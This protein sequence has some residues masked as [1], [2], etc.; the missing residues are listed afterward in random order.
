MTIFEQIK[1][2]LKQALK[3]GQKDVAQTL[4]MIMSD[5]KNEAVNSGTDR[6][7]ISDEI[8]MKILEKAVKNRKDSI[9]IYTESGRTDLAEI[10][11][12]EIEIIEKY[13]PEQLTDDELKKIVDEIKVQNPT[14]HGM[15]L[16]GKIMPHVKGKAD[17]ERIKH[18]L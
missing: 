13:L 9:R 7:N 6:E 12:Q 18:L 1:E 16:M 10:E 14:L 5:I 4:R 15:I 3:A 2:E 8:S 11:A 17:P